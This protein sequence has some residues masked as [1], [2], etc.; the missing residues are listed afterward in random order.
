MPLTSEFLITLARSESSGKL[1]DNQIKPSQ[2]NLIPLE[3]RVRLSANKKDVQKCKYISSKEKETEYPD[4]AR[5]YIQIW[6]LDSWT[7]ETKKKGKTVKETG[8]DKD[9]TITKSDKTKKNDFLAEFGGFIKEVKKGKEY[10]F[11]TDGKGTTIP[12]A[13]TDKKLGKLLLKMDQLQKDGPTI[14][15]DVTVPIQGEV[16][17]I[18][19]IGVVYQETANQQSYTD[20]YS[21]PVYHI[22]N[23]SKIIQEQLNEGGLRMLCYTEYNRNIDKADLKFYEQNRDNKKLTGKKK[24]PHVT[25]DVRENLK[26][27][28]TELKKNKKYDGNIPAQSSTLSIYK[29]VNDANFPY[30]SGKF[31]KEVNSLYINSKN[32]LEVRCFEIFGWK[33]IRSNVNKLIEAVYKQ[34]MGSTGEKPKVLKLGIYCHG[35]PKI[36]CTAGRLPDQAGTGKKPVDNLKISKVPEFVESFI[37]REGEKDRKLLADNVLFA[38]YACS[39]GRSSFTD[40]GVSYRD[41]SKT[42]HIPRSGK[43]EDNTFGKNLPPGKSL[44]EGSFA[45]ALRDALHLNGRFPKA[46]VYSHTT[47]GTADANPKI[48]LFY[49]NKDVDMVSVGKSAEDCRHAMFK[50]PEGL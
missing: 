32:E 22:R 48:R 33:E 21:R 46:H 37:V 49:T 34:Y 4:D 38:L 45:R 10:K 24:I 11:V 19:E 25:E 17:T 12:K 44:G 6:E 16:E 18:L 41:G 8:K 13:P 2:S 3:I 50:H 26:D 28:L 29:I 47:V 15:K 36:L 42:V 31:A 43:K 20:N 14:K 40:G 5:C 27:W 9:S 39:T 35:E 23:M 1:K 30:A 7:V